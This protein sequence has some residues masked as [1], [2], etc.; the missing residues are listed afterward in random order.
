MTNAKPTNDARIRAAILRV[1]VGQVATYGSIAKAAKLPGAARRVA[2]VLHG[3]IG[4]PWHRILGA[5][6]EIKLRGEAYFE[7]RF[8]LESEGVT[9]HGRR[10]NMKK[11]EHKFIA[12]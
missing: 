4:L 5:G 1:P 11:H 10:V 2:M 6:G 9:F 8:R 7:Q 3:A 12:R